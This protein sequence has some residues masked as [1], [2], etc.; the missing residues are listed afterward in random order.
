MQVQVLIDKHP[1]N[2]NQIEEERM[3]MK[4]SLLNILKPA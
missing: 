3:R 2:N 4:A 1:V